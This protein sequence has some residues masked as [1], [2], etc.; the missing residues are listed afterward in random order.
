MKS[1]LCFGC[2]DVISKEHSGRN[3]PKRI[4]CNI[5][6]EQHSTGLYRLQSDKRSPEK[7]DDNHTPPMSPANEE[8]K[9]SIKT[10]ALT[11]VHTEVISMCAIPVKVKYKDS[12]SVYSTFAMPDNCSQGCFV[13]SS[14]VKNLRIKGCKTSVS[15]K[16]LTGERIH[17][18]FA[19][20]GL[21]VTRTSGLD[22][23]WI[24]IPK[25]YTKVDLS[26]DSSEIAT[27]GKIKKWKYLQEISEEISESDD[28]KVELL[29][30]A[31]CPRALE[32]G[33]VI[34]SRQSN[35]EFS[36]S[37]QNLHKMALLA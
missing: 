22:A 10:C 30:V 33:Q 5:C 1:K 8:K 24:N 11:V 29:M 32:P 16:T 15:V 34:A 9:D 18:S 6:K 23:E 14:L 13:I 7:E 2:Y 37:I 12:N 35:L 21:K 3:Y 20:G 28:V 25:T 31:N 19:V 4:K 27:P 36:G 17:T 26:V